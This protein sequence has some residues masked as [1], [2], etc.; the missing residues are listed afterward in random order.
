MRIETD[1]ILYILRAVETGGITLYASKDPQEVY[2]GVVHYEASNG[3]KIGIFNDCNEWDYIQYIEAPDGRRMDFD[4]IED[5][6]E[7]RDYRPT[8]E[9][10]RQEYG[11]PEEDPIC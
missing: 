10:I 9:V 3:W 5:T 11:I 1:E 7:L 8:I 4:A 6:P 2:A